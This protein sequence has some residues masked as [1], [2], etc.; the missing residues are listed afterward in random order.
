MSDLECDTRNMMVV[1]IATE[2]DASLTIEY[3]SLQFLQP[4][5]DDTYG[6]ILFLNLLM[7]IFALSVNLIL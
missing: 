7:C 3:I 6:S 1:V 5:V 4:P 2:N